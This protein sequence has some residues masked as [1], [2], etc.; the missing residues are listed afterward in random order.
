MTF[1]GLRCSPLGIVSRPKVILLYCN[2]TSPDLRTR[3]PTLPV[4]TRDRRDTVNAARKMVW[5]SSPVGQSNRARRF[6]VDRE[7]GEP[8]H[9]Y[10]DTGL[11]VATPSSE[12][13][14][15]ER[16]SPSQVSAADSH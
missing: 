1:Q 2:P 10:H 6:D 11:N 12:G 9:P 4:G 5:S 8:V 14:E 7:I 16:L 3:N 15:K 13:G